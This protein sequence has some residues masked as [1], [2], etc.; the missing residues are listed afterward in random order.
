MVRVERGDDGA[1]VVHVI[2]AEE[3]AAACPG[4][5]VVATSVK[6]YV[7]TSPKDIPYGQD[8][9]LV[10]WNKTRWRCKEDYCQRGSFTEAIA[11]V[12]ARSRMTLRL[13]T[14]IGSAIGDAARSVAEVADAHGVSWPTAHRAFM[15]HADEQ[16]QEPQPTP[17]LGIDETRRGKPR[18]QRHSETGRWERIDPWDTGFVDLTGDQGLLGQTQGRTAAAVIDWLA[19]RTPQ[20]RGAVEFVAIDPA[21]GYA[22]AVRAALPN[23]AI[24]VDHFHLVKLANDAL[25]KVRRRVT[26]DLRERR[27]RKLD[28][29]WANRRRLLCARERLSD[30]S[31]TK[32]W[33][34]LAAEDPGSQ[35]LSAWIAKE[36]LRTLCSTVRLGGDAHLTRHRLHRF[37]AWC[38]DSNIP[39]LLTLATTVD[40]WWPEINAFVTTGITNARTEGYNRLVKQVKRVGCGFRN[41]E[42]SAYRI[43]FHCTR[44]Q[45]AATQTSHRLPG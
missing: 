38:I 23:A 36:E 6:E 11:Q 35:I 22:A 37:L 27:G 44:K 41:Q 30:K 28:P 7:S 4:C 45:R 29:E 40:T 10:Q 26:W 15:S 13:C 31:F 25:T 9:I 39:E 32:M 2:T 34:A 24:V 12:P 43:R 3:A 5:G 17:I 19:E 1:R 18:W 20:F 14:A 8:R 21:A 16:L 42:H 33:N